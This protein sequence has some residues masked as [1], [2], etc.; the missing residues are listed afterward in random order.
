MLKN[1]P[2][3][4]EMLAGDV[5]SIPGSGRSPGAGNGILLQYSRLGNPRDSRSWWAT[6]QR[7]AKESDM[8]W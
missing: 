2:A 6:V 4:Q 7:V 1:L 3:M 5:S 8:T